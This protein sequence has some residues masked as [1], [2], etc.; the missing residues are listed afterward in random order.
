MAG[1]TL[2]NIWHLYNYYKMD[3]YILQCM[4]TDHVNLNIAPRNILS[5]LEEELLCPPPKKRTRSKDNHSRRPHTYS[6][7]ERSTGFAA[8]TEEPV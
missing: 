3:A 5:T 2:L 7:L 8:T 1:W 6:T 4:A